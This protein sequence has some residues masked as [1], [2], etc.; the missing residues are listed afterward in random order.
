[1]NKQILFWCP[2][3]SNVGTINA[4]LQ[5]ALALS[6]S[7]KIDCKIMNVYGEF[8]NYN[9]LFKENNIKEIRLI[10]NNLIKCFPKKGFF[11]SRLSYLWI[12]FF[13]FIPLLNYLRRNKDDVLFVYL[14]SSLP[15]IVISLFGLKNKIIFRISG[16]VKFSYL[17]KFIWRLAKKKIKRILIQTKLA[18]KKL[19]DQNIFDKKNILYLEDPIIDLKKIN[20]LKKQSIEKKFYKTNFFIAIG[21]LTNQKNFSFLIKN[22]EKKIKNDNFYLLILGDGEEKVKLL[23]MIK[24]KQLENKVYLLGHKKNIYKYLNKSKGLICT[25]LWE[26]PGFI[27][28]EA[29]ACK[30]IILTSDCESGPSE[31]LE[32]GKHGFIFKSNNSRSFINNFNSMNNNKSKHKKM[33]NKNYKKILNYTK[34]S[35]VEKITNELRLIDSFNKI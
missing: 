3:L 10:K 17:R 30:K 14:L 27:I 20:I 16:K 32:Y 13:S 33:I 7:K 18:K 28:Q 2:F 5:S 23:E 29:A 6:K 26:E 12:F 9:K 11:W 25:S 24:E 31:F 8:D 22:I 35:F 34:K 15:F 19:I 21:R 4:V 1:M